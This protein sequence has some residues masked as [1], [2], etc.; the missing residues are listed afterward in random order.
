MHLTSKHTRSHLCAGGNT[1]LKY[2]GANPSLHVQLNEPSVFVHAAFVSQLPVPSRH[3]LISAQEM[4]SPVK[5]L[6]HVHVKSPSVLRHWAFS[7][8]LSV[9]AA[10]SSTSVQ[11][12]PLPVKPQASKVLQS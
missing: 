3:S 9:S 1:A 2:N 8:Q 5:P 4:P 7:W 11:V 6:L 12:V 10:H